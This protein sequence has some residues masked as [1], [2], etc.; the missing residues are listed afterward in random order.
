LRDHKYLAAGYP[1]ATGCV[2]GA[3]RHIVVDRMEDSGMRWVM[4]GAQSMLNLRSTD[5]V[6]WEQMTAAA[7]WSESV[8]LSSVVKNGETYVLVG[9]HNDDRT[10][11][12][13]AL[14]GQP[15]DYPRP[16]HGACWL[17]W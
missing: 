13:T 7:A 6:S 16:F 15:L 10:A 17:A 8:G 2:E 11:R 5:G 12:L 3:C 14:R 1:I 4:G 9:L